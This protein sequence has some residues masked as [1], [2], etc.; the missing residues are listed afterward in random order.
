ME[1]VTAHVHVFCPMQAAVPP[2]AGVLFD[3]YLLPLCSSASE[4][5]LLPG[6]VEGEEHVSAELTEFVLLTVGAVCETN[7]S[8]LT[9]L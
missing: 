1:S 9:S 8:S 6:P 2:L 4:R 7:R 3:G 5:L